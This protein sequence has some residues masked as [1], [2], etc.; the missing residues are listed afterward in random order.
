MLK[1]F[2]CAIGAVAACLLLFLT[3]APASAQSL[4]SRCSGCSGWWDLNSGASPANL[5]PGGEGDVTLLAENLGDAGLS[6]AVTLTDKLPAGLTAQSVSLGFGVLGEQQPFYG[7]LFCQVQPQEVTCTLP[8]ELVPQ[9]L[10]TPYSH[11]EA[12]ISVSVAGGAKSGEVNEVS[13]SGGGIS[14]ASTRAPITVSSQATPFGVERY[15]LRPENA[16]GAI[17]TQAGSHPF[18]LTSVINLNQT[19]EPRYPPAAVKDLRF[20]L[21]A[22]LIGNPTPFRQCS[23]TK[24]TANAGEGQNFC[25]DNTV[26]GVASVSI[27]YPVGGVP[28]TFAVPLYSLTPT[29]GE[30]ARFG[31]DV[32]ADPVYLDTSVRTGSDYGVTVTVPDIT[33]VAGFI[34]S[35]VTFWGVP[36]DPR[37]DSVRGWNCISP[38]EHAPACTATEEA[39]PPP[40]LTL[41]TSCEGAQLSNVETDSWEQEGVFLAPVQYTLQDVFGQQLGMDGCN[42]LPFAPSISVAPDGQAGSTPTGL[43][44]HVRVPQESAL[45]GNGFAEGEVRDTTVKLPEGVTLNSAA[46]DGLQACS[47]SEIGYLPAESSPPDELKFTSGL[48]QP[49]CPEASKVGT[50]TIKT[51]LLP[52]PLE[53]AVYLATQEQNPFRSLLAL[54]IVAEDPISGTLVK[55][56]G[57]VLPDARTGQLTS[58]FENTPQLPFEELEL[59]F[60]GGERAPLSTPTHCGSYTTEASFTPWSSSTPVHSISSF[61]ITSGPNGSACP[62]AALPFDP[63][64]NAG[65]TNIQAGAF[66]PFTMTMS[67]E[68]GQ[69]NLQAI[70]L[71]M[72]AGLSGML[73]S[74]TQCGEPQA[75]RGTCGPESEIG[76]TIVSVGL[77]GDPYTVKGKVFITGPY[78]GAPFGL[79]IVTPAVAGPFNL[80][81]VVVRAKIEVDPHTA[82]L[83]VTSDS[84]GPYA[85]PTILDGIPLQIK[86]VNVTI[87]R[88]GFTFNPTSCEK[89][90]ITGALTSAEGSSSSLAVPFQV[91]NC[92]S[93]AF[94]PG[95]LAA[96]NAK[97]TRKDG[98]RLQ[99]TV[100]SHS[101]DAN[102]ASVRV[103]LPKKLPSRLSTLQQ[104][105]TEAQFAADPAGCPAASVVG[106]AVVHTPVIASPLKGPAYFVSHGGAKFPELIIVLQGEGVTVEL[107]GETFISK[108]GITSSTFKTVPDVPFSSFQLTLPQGPHSALAA[109]GNLCGGTLAMPTR[110]V[111]QNGALIERNTKIA[112]SGCAAARKKGKAGPGKR[113]KRSQRRRSRQHKHKAGK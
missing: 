6:S 40:L 105:C 75:D 51:P 78:E 16:N 50:V 4:Q 68:D 36:G 80:G 74:V 93:L 3:A 35:R 12:S 57:E 44:I 71:Q 63:S 61:N 46:A 82:A 91:T 55:L 83:T 72:P 2:R 76:E 69:Q 59:H 111:G 19:S 29:V 99:V 10:A 88:P 58:T 43:S 104:A 5:P 85:I 113:R 52:N 25:P 32:S 28:S 7:V 20:N 101:G 14:S 11:I 27:A 39:S 84:S 33:E 103:E 65:A 18:Q 112:V 110:I 54:Y 48:P 102:I 56:P 94:K 108:A 95:F 97:H 70:K 42:Q 107:N 22:G 47:E 21:P 67:R 34:S 92:A 79:S 45:N 24:F 64:L 23:L 13:V 26:V 38:Q 66:S 86:H 96:T 37:H 8:E 60:F 41:P 73:S 100:S 31:F 30:P 17:D 90:A 77:G 109:T 49:F 81:T 87:D 62:G 9:F 1:S 89:T 53:G 15:E 98:A 106:N